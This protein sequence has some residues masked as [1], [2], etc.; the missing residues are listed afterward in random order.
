MITKLLHRMGSGVSNSLLE[1]E[2]RDR[3]NSV[4][5]V[6]DDNIFSSNTA[7][8][9]QNHSSKKNSSKSKK[10]NRLSLKC[11]QDTNIPQDWSDLTPKKCFHFTRLNTNKEINDEDIEKLFSK[12]YKIV[13]LIGRGASG[14]VYKIQNN[15]TKKYYACKIINIDN[16]TK[17]NDYATMTT[18]TN[19]LRRLNS[20]YIINM[21]ELYETSD[22]MWIIMELANGGDLLEGISNLE[23]FSEYAVS[24][25][26]KQILL[27]IKYLHS[28]GIVHRD[29]KID[30]ILYSFYENNSFDE[31]AS[32]STS[33]IS[34]SSST[35]NNSSVSSSTSPT[36][37]TNNQCNHLASTIEFYVKLTDFGLSAHLPIKR[38]GEKKQLKKLKKYNKLKELWG[39]T[40]YFAPEMYEKA[41]GF[42][43]DIWA[44]G[45]LLYEMLTGELAFPTPEVK[46]SLFD[47]IMLN[48]GKDVRIFETRDS[49]NSISALGQS[50]IKGMLR[51]DPVRRFDIDEC[52]E[53]P[54]IRDMPK[55]VEKEVIQ[56]EM[57]INQQEKE[58]VLN[59]LNEKDSFFIPNASTINRFNEKHPKVLEDNF[60]YSF[61]NTEVNI[62]NGSTDNEEHSSKKLKKKLQEKSDNNSSQEEDEEEHEDDSEE[63]IYDEVETL[64]AINIE[65]IERERELERIREEVRELELKYDKEFSDSE[66]KKEKKRNKVKMLPNHVL[67]NYLEN[68]KVPSYK[69]FF[70]V[71][72]EKAHKLHK[73]R[74]ERRAKRHQALVKDFDLENKSK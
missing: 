64:R 2:F 22:K 53:H 10:S 39:T 49:W 29:I 4:V 14:E 58:K 38:V 23:N 5:V 8:T 34:S 31:Y 48:S 43:V 74:V 55:Y 42:Q 41:Y 26:F 61:N 7:I 57:N 36:T 18:E 62:D 59:I 33:P 69:D 15:V 9:V 24:K 6:P 28:K 70:C 45:C 52:L 3:A 47:R 44:L 17:M 1:Y 37:P 16:E 27:S 20:P 56:N 73:Q 32:A 71:H 66:S 30:N 25:I 50:L 12:T 72:L 54:W 21:Y 19:I 65:E 40:E 67:S 51:V 60:N 13:S 68:L 35:E 63:D 11:D 46:S